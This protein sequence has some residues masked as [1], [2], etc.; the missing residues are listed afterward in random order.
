MP[1]QATTGVINMR[2]AKPPHPKKSSK[3]F[4]WPKRSVTPEQQERF[5]VFLAHKMHEMRH[6]HI[7]LAKY[8]WGTTAAGGTAGSQI[9]KWLRMEKFPGE[10]VAAYLAQYFKTSLEEMLQDTRPYKDP[11]PLIVT[12]AGVTPALAGVPK[13]K[14]GNFPEPKRPGP[15]KKKVNGHAPQDSRWLLPAGA[16]AP[17]IKMET[18]ERPMMMIVDL[19]AE[20]PQHVALAVSSMVN[21]YRHADDEGG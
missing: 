5:A 15:K 19:K 12:Q 13:K 11:S 9:A 18:A 20:L 1:K 14:P 21:D 8:L 6:T 2:G 16:A 7:S 10:R 17:H 3:G 4:E